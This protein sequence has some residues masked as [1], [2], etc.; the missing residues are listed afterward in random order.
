MSIAKT[1]KVIFI[2]AECLNYCLCLER[3]VTMVDDLPDNVVLY[4]FVASN[5]STYN[6]NKFKR[7]KNM[8]GNLTEI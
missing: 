1:S 5:I 8:K 7:I 6:F 2:S 3:A 4:H